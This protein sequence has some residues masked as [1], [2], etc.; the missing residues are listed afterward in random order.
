MKSECGR[1]HHTAMSDIM[2]PEGTLGH[3]SRARGSPQAPYNT[4][5]SVS[6][7]FMTI[8]DILR[9]CNHFYFISKEADVRTGARDMFDNAQMSLKLHFCFK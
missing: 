8:Y 4:I 9:I 3:H 2:R 5:L 7:C 1:F 6:F